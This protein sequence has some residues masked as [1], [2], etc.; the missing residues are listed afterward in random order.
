MCFCY[1]SRLPTA[2]S[3]ITSTKSF[4]NSKEFELFLEEYI[5]AASEG[6]RMC[7]ARDYQT[8]QLVRLGNAYL[9]FA[10]CSIWTL[11][12]SDA[13]LGPF[14]DSQ[15]RFERTVSL[16]GIYWN[17]SCG[18][19]SWLQDL[20]SAQNGLFLQEKPFILGNP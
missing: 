2:R 14:Y 20:P 19:W 10:L 16:A 5:R 9:E 17:Y 12:G 6:I 1:A 11:Y 13:H 4:I 18:S 15:S 8:D 3:I 7:T